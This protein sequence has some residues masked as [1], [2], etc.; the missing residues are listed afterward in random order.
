ML[1]RGLL[2]H[3]TTQPC[4]YF[5]LPYLTLPCLTI[6]LHYLAKGLPTLYHQPFSSSFSLVPPGAFRRSRH[7]WGEGAFFTL[8]CFTLHYFTLL[9]LFSVHPPLAW[10]GRSSLS[11]APLPH[12]RAP[13]PHAYPG[14]PCTGA[15]ACKCLFAP[16]LVLQGH[17]LCQHQPP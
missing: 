7:S 8:L 14:P 10:P 9:Y 11:H 4:L 2:E 17:K 1:D 12:P 6:A 16:V 15:M 3:S 13:T 5:T